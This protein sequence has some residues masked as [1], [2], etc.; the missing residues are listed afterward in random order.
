M[1]FLSGTV[2][3]AKNILKTTLTISKMWVKKTGPLSDHFVLKE[4]LSGRYLGARLPVH[5]YIPDLSL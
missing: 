3:I 4:K 2:T 5:L 1:F